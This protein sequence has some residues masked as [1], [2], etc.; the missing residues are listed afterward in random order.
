MSWVEEVDFP[1]RCQPIVVLD[2]VDFAPISLGETPKVSSLTAASIYRIFD[3][4][5]F[6]LVLF[7][8][9]QIEVAAAESE[10]FRR[11]WT[12]VASCELG[13]IRV[14]PMF[15]WVYHSSFSRF[16][17]FVK[18]RLIVKAENTPSSKERVVELY[19]LENRMQI[20]E[21]IEVFRSLKTSEH[22]HDH[23]A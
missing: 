4:T 10:G 18:V 3:N 15:S 5:W 9:F 12:R 21:I 23:T 16:L 19:F 2:C 8:N 7:T 17:W 20:K 11:V 22:A 14:L 1:A 6:E 13:L